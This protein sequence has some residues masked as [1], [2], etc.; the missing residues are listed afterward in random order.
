MIRWS[1]KLHILTFIRFVPFLRHLAVYFQCWAHYCNNNI[2]SRLM[3]ISAPFLYERFFWKR[4]TIKAVYI[5]DLIVKEW[6]D[7]TRLKF[8]FVCERSRQKVKKIS[9]TDKT[10]NNQLKKYK[11]SNRKKIAILFFVLIFCFFQ[12]LFWKS[13]FLIIDD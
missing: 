3:G 11:Y 2:H 4:V 7:P 5:W 1:K 12:V 9:I 6:F 13:Y 10:F 8:K